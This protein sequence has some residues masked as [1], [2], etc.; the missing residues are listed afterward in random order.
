MNSSTEIRIS[1]LGR[2]EA[3][4]WPVVGCSGDVVV[5]EHRWR[6]VVA[7]SFPVELEQM[8]QQLQTLEHARKEPAP[9]RWADERGGLLPMMDEAERLLDEM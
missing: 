7:R 4:D 2:A 6:R 1:L 8:A 3:L 9:G 5:G